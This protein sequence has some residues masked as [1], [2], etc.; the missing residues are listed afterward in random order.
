MPTPEP[1]TPAPPFLTDAQRAHLAVAL[2][3]LEDELAEVEHL[4]T[5]TPR[6]TPLRLELADLPTDF[7]RAIAAELERARAQ[8]SA[9][10]VS[11]G[12]ERRERSRAREIQGLLVTMIV[13]ADEAASRGLRGY[14]PVDPSLPPVLDTSLDE[15]RA[16]FI[17]ILACLGTRASYPRDSR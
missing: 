15:I 12:L 5:A 7:S 9:L 4:A 11:L 10:A 13:Q 6:R 16:A 17:R 8:F 1:R 3:H 14:G 2:A